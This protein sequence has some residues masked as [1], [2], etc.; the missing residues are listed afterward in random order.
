MERERENAREMAK[1]KIMSKRMVV[2]EPPFMRLEPAR[3]KV[4]RT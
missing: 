4:G 3:L 2:M 1:V